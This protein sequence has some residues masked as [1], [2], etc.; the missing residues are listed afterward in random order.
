MDHQP[1]LRLLVNEDDETVTL[2]P[3]S[4]EDVTLPATEWLT[5]SAAHV[6]DVE[7]MR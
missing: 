1:P 4:L 7:E 6:V 5:V 2:S 3:R